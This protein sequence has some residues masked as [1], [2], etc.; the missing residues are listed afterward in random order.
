MTKLLG[1]VGN[2]IAHSLSP[3][4]HNGWL[5]DAGID[6]AYEAFHVPDDQFSKTL[7]DLEKR[8]LFGLNVTLPHKGA[9]LA[10]A[11]EVSEAARKIGAANT[12]SQTRN[13]EWRADNT[14]A[15][16]FLRSL[17]SVD[18]KTDRA[19]ILGAGGSARAL[20][21]AL[22]NV[23]VPVT[24]LNRT[25]EKARSLADEFGYEKT[26]YG[27]IDQLNDNIENATIVINT[28]RMGHGGEVF[29]LPNGMDRLFY[30]ISYGK[31]ARPQLMHAETQGWK[32]KD[33]LGML[34]AQAAY[35]FQ[36]WFG[37]LPDFDTGLHR[38]RLALEAAS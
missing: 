26:V 31:I 3:L 35:S 1:V 27:S 28:T 12:L 14:D 29:T 23:G 20:V 10:A 22:T 30:D 7:D 6:A 18:S 5:H 8:D 2:P 16:G 13:G 36:I 33:G 25:V 11:A 19:L 17:G 38:C 24:V 9:A 21:F 37:V 34:V 32:T 15:P 4:I